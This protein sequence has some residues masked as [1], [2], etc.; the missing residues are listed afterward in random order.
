MVNLRR[1]LAALSIASQACVSLLAQATATTMTSSNYSPL[2]GQPFTL[3]ATVTPAVATGKVTFYDG[4][5]ILGI[6]P[7]NGGKA[8]ASTSLLVTGGRIVTAYYTPRPTWWWRTST[9]T[10]SR[11]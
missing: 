11:I 6:A 7:L 3:T 10:A 2:F 1:V 8:S 9:A 4:V 5:T